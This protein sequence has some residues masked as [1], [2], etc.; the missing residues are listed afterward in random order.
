MV[1]DASRERC[2]PRTTLSVFRI[3]SVALLFYLLVP[4][5]LIPFGLAPI[6]VAQ[7]PAAEPSALQAIQSALRARDYDQASQLIQTQLR[8][9]P[10]DIRLLTMQGI[11][12]AA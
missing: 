5:G 6:A 1:I 8:Q 11:A 10:Q 9:E 12:L 2:V 7:T 4:H 3:P